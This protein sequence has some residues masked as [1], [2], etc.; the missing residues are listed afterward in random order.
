MKFNKSLL[1][2]SVV[3]LS[4]CLKDVFSV[5]PYFLRTDK[6]Q[7]VL[8]FRPKKSGSIV[9]KVFKKKGQK[10]FLPINELKKDFSKKIVTEVNVGKQDCGEELKILLYSSDFPSLEGIE[11]SFPSY[12]CNDEITFGIISDT[13][14]NKKRHRAIG[15]KLKT[16]ENLSFN[17]H[18]GDVV[19]YA[20]HQYQWKKFFDQA[21]PTYL[22]K[23]PI[24]S[25]VG[26][27]A[28]YNIFAKWVGKGPVP[29]QFREYMRW[30]GSP[31][32]GYISLVYPQFEMITINS[33]LEKLTKE[34]IKSQWIWLE[35]KLILAQQ[36]N[37]PVIVGMHYSPYCSNVGG[38]NGKDEKILRKEMIPLLEKYKVKLVLTGHTHTYERL[39]KNG[40]HYIIQ[41]PAGGRKGKPDRKDDY[42]VLIKP[43][44]DTFGIVSVNKERILV[45]TLNNKNETIDSLRIGL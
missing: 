30:D 8:K 31:K 1:L 22:G 6:N 35:E 13:Q 2:I 37:R 36:Y 29:D 39:F 7:I 5:H 26:N 4:S 14:T 44:I 43:G 34:E 18:L 28:F 25:V 24:I 42:T 9:V 21:G 16:Y 33:I 32:I 3:F 27:H 10:N 19:D 38:F 15:E 12:P 23:T 40:V 11:R 17:L 45:K 20:V 41:G